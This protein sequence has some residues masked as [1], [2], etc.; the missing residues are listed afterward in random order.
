MDQAIRQRMALHLRSERSLGLKML[1]VRRTAVPERMTAPA[2]TPAPRLNQAHP[3]GTP[4]R[5][6]VTAPRVGAPAAP[7]RGVAPAASAAPAVSSPPIGRIDMAVPFESPVLP[8]EEKRR[9][10]EELHEAQVRGCTRCTLCETRTNVVF[11]EGDVDAGIFFI[12][13]GPG[14]TEDRMARPFVG[15]AGQLLDKMI[16]GMGLQREQVFIANIVKCRP[17]GNRAPV[18]DEVAACTPFLVRQIELV[19]PKVIVTLGLPAMK[20]L[21]QTNLSMGRMRGRWHEW[22][23]IMVMPTYHPAYILRNY[24]REVREAVW[25]DLKSVMAELGRPAMKSS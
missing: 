6:A 7:R 20:F 9:L 10:L 16:T 15:R 8:A 14:E 13:E 12:G 21:L 23:G 18:P 19:R 17:P 1:P 5:A 2:S 11:G 3:G 24:T 4:V 22:R 25:S